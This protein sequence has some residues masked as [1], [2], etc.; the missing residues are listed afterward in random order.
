MAAGKHIYCV[1]LAQS[2][3]TLHLYSRSTTKSAS[4]MLTQHHQGV[5]H[6]KDGDTVISCTE[7]IIDIVPRS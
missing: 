3:F 6:N 2:R 4:V 5:Y 7:R 1:A